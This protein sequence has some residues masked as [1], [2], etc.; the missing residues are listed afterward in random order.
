MPPAAKEALDLTP[1]V[2]DLIIWHNDSVPRFCS[3]T[4]LLFLINIRICLIVMFNYYKE[5]LLHC[6]TEIIRYRLKDKKTENIS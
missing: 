2:H 6:L 3:H 1:L 4:Y 5:M